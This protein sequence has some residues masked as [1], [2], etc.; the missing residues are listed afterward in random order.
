MTCIAISRNEIEKRT[1]FFPVLYSGAESPLPRTIPAPSRPAPLR[2][3]LVALVLLG[4]G[5]PTCAGEAVRLVEVY[6]ADTIRIERPDGARA[7]IRLL[8]VDAPEVEGKYRKAELGGKAAAAFA[9]AL[10]RPGPIT[11]EPDPGGDDVDKYG[12]LLRYVRLPDGRDAGAEI[13]LAGFA[14][15]YRR[16]RY[17]RRDSYVALENRAKAEGRGLWGEMGVGE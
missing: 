14:R 1:C 8:G 7:T 5:T 9:R 15:A 17:T 12:R 13:L 10:M 16:Y 3:F 6:D 4:A 2:A 11:L